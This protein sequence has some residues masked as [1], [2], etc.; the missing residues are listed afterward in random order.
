M[1]PMTAAHERLALMLELLPLSR[2]ELA[3]R[4]GVNE[5]ARA[6]TARPPLHGC[7]SP[8]GEGEEVVMMSPSDQVEYAVE[9]WPGSIDDVASKVGVPKPKLMAWLKGR[10]EPSVADADRVVD[11]VRALL[12]AALNKL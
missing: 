12:Q 1:G 3:H 5:P 11:A 10:E 7:G 6:T 9:V 2:G 4:L 8:R